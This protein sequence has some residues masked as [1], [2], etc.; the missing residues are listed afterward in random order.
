MQRGPY[1][2]LGRGVE[3]VAA[4]AAPGEAGEGALGVVLADVMAGAGE[5]GLDVAKRGVHLVE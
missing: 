4:V 2:P 3:V 1:Q 5:R